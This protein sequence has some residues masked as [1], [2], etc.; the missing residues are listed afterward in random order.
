M[1]KLTKYEFRK[2]ITVPTVLLIVIGLLEVVMLVGL[3]MGS[4]LYTVLGYS[5]QML[6]MFFSF[7]MILILSIISY[8]KELR[9]KSSYMTFMAPVS[10]YQVIGSKLLSTFIIAALAGILFFVL[11]PLNSAA[12][13]S[14]LDE[15]GNFMD[16]M[17]E[18]IEFF[19]YNLKKIII[20][21]AMILFELM[22]SF[23]FVVVLAYFAISLSSTVFQ[24]KKFKWVVSSI[25]FIAL[26]ALI[27]YISLKLPTIGEPTTLTEAFVGELPMLLF[28]LV[29]IVGGYVGSAILLEKKISL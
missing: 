22:I 29:C 2:N 9:S 6:V 21:G 4:E 18:L 16:I 19:G 26:Y 5:V 27:S 13:A 28:Y 20:N 24:N 3:A 1:F 17:K 8:S 23:Y 12:I 10:A 11:L 7:F 25:I 14:T 15:V